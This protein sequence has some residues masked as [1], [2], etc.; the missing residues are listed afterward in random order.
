MIGLVGAVGTELTAIKQIITDRLE[1]FNYS[2][3]EIRIS[4]DII[5]LFEDVP[6]DLSYYDKAN[7]LMSAGN[8][9]RQKSGDNS[10]LALA[11]ASQISCIRE[12]RSTSDDPEPLKRKAIISCIRN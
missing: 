9:I 1:T 3:E 2:F 8:T 11:A 12:Q 7:A 6:N 5:S 4:Q 10:I